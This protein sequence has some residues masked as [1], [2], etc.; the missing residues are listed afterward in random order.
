M[1]AVPIACSVVTVLAHLYFTVVTV[2]VGMTGQ[3]KMLEHIEGILPAIKEYFS[4]KR[5]R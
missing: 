3:K 5:V 2:S 1:S 4:V